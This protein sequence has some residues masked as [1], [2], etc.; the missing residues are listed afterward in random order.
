[1]T[2]T[3]P[4]DMVRCSVMPSLIVR[5][6]RRTDSRPHGHRFRDFANMLDEEPDQRAQDAILQRQDCD[7]V[8]PDLQIDRQYFQRVPAS[9]EALH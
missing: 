6:S 2:Q 9:I 5:D 3:G 1:M 8:S 7:R 4:L